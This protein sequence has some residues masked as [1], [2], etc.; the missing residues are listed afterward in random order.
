MVSGTVFTLLN[1]GW[2]ARFNTATPMHTGRAAAPNGPM[3]LLAACPGMKN[4][5]T[6]T[7]APQ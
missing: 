5:S 6:N 2:S 7:I 1:A 4:E 3:R